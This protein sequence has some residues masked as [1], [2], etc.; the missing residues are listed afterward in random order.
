MNALVNLSKKISY[1]RSIVTN[2]SDHNNGAFGSVEQIEGPP[3]PVK[4]VLS[5]G[6]DECDARSSGAASGSLQDS[7]SL[8]VRRFLI[9]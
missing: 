5:V 7:L 1:Y 3:S 2:G 4:R 9:S 6:S 8:S